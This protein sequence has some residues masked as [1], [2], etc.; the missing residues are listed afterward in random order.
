A[1]LLPTMASAQVSTASVRGQVIGA[2]GKGA[3][4]AQV[5]ARSTATNQT[6]R[7]TGDANGG[8][9][10]T[11]LRPGEYEVT[12]TAGAETTSQLVVVAVG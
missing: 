12:A 4:G 6:W 11:G 9:T 7:A 2:D 8:Y 5:T 3:A 1:V 10:L